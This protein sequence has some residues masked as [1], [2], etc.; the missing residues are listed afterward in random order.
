MSTERHKS[1]RSLLTLI[2]ILSI[3]ISIV[4]IDKSPEKDKPEVRKMMY[5]HYTGMKDKF[6]NRENK[7]YA[8]DK[9]TRHTQHTQIV[10]SHRTT[11][12]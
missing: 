12:K 9:Y 1:D 10:H 4:Y 3:F 2:R 6:N 11:K 8:K 5:I 7:S